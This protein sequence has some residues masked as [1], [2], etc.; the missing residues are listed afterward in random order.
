MPRPKKCRRVC[1][2]PKYNEFRVH[3]E[4]H[5]EGEVVVLTVDEYEAIRL[6]DKEGY[7][8]EECSMYM[9]VARTTV[10]QIYT[11]ARKKLATVLVDGCTLKIQGGDYQLC[12]SDQSCCHRS[13]CHKGLHSHCNKEEERA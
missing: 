4:E 8:Q 11:S 7:S 1:C 10:Q 13:C 9:N 12:E 3:Q 2:M 6:I 5:N